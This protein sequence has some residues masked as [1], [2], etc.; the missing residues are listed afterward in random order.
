MTGKKGTFELPIRLDVYATSE[1][2][3]SRK[4]LYDGSFMGDH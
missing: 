1:D 2:E 3:A 4:L